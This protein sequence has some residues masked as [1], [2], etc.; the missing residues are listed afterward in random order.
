MPGAHS[1]DPTR[2]PAMLPV[3]DAPGSAACPPSPSC[4]CRA[5]VMLPR[6]AAFAS[7]VDRRPQWVAWSLPGRRTAGEA[8]GRAP[9]ASERAELG[10]RTVACNGLRHRDLVL[11]RD[12]QPV[13]QWRACVRASRLLWLASRLDTCPSP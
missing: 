5:F 9:A 12:V 1:P 8:R 3:L 11:I 13:L 7:A 6:T 10:Y 2:L 4:R